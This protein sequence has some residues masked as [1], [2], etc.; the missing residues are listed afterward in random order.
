M[1]GQTGT[2]LLW[3]SDVE[4]LNLRIYNAVPDNGV[5]KLIQSAN[6][7]GITKF[8][9]PVFGDAR[10][11]LGTTQGALY[12]L[13]SP[14]NPP[15]TCSSPNDF[16]SVVINSTS[17]VKT[18]QCQANIQTQVTAINLTGNANFQITGKPTLPVTVAAGN[19]I[20]F[21]AV[22]NPKQPGPLSSD[23]QLS[24]NNGVTGYSAVTPVTLKGVGDSLDPLL[25]VSPN[26]VSFDGIITGQQTGGV[27]QSIIFANQGDGPLTIL[28]LD[29]S[30]TSE[31]GA[32]VQPTN[33]D[34]GP[35][36]GPF[37]FQNIPKT[38][39]K[40]SQ[41]VININFDPSTSGNFAVYVHVRSNGGTKI[42]DVVGTSGT[43]PKALLEFQAA[44]GSGTWIPYTNNTPPFT[45]G[46]VSEQDTKSLKMRLTNVGDKNAG[47]LSVTVSKPPFGV[48]GI[49]GAANGVDLAEGTILR[50][51]ESASA[52]LFCSVPKSQ[53][54]VDSY[55]GTAVWTLNTGD[56]NFG[57]QFIQFTCTAVA[58]QVGP[59]TA[60][61][62]A[63]YRYAGCYKENNPGRQLSYQ[64]YSSADN[65]IGK[66]ITACA[67]KKYKYAGTQYTVECW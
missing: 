36:V 49:I 59:L 29:Y 33:T 46:S 50:A 64:A 5:L 22:F 31:T 61:G 62:S 27:S 45:F 15:L 4:G 40:G 8:T 9:R 7:P 56:P 52:S 41:A 65:T 23:V 51:G 18:I 53:L 19:N 25:S 58:D 32:L 17:D 66:C 67:A 39:A 63:T 21:Q 12:C 20:S 28:G 37:T 26:V 54:N 38:I 11:Y 3:V 57:K 35:Q 13:G 2:G 42:F 10:V 60:N 55:N 14:V 43:Y 30:T 1:N 34:K 6:L 16:G 48:Q 24:T 47:S 44:D